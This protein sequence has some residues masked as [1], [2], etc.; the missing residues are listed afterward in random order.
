MEKKDKHKT[1]AYAQI[2]ALG[3]NSTESVKAIET[4]IGDMDIRILAEPDYADFKKKGGQVTD[5]PYV[6]RA[7]LPDVNLPIQ[8]R[9][10]IDDTV[11][12]TAAEAFEKTK[13]IVEKYAEALKFIEEL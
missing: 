12:E 2:K 13:Q 4:R 6:Y 9:R 1:A 10:K 11:Y 5:R 3:G 7:T 8:I